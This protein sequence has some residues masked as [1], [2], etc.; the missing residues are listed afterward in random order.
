MTQTDLQVDERQGEIIVTSPASGFIAVYTKPAG[1]PQ[2]VLKRRTQIDAYEL[3]AERVAA[4]AYCGAAAG[5]V[6]G[7]AIVALGTVGCT[8]VP[9]A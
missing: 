5:G 4:L 7:G 3:L 2:L 8:G 6:F 1:Q 9:S